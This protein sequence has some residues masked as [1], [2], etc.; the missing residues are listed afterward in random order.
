M[1]K[2]YFEVEAREGKAW[3]MYDEPFEFTID[4]IEAW[5]DMLDKGYEAR[6]TCR[7]WH[8]E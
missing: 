4:A 3:V 7:L 5:Q 8:V 2:Q 1:H 6:I